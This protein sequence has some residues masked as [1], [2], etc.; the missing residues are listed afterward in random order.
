MHQI[1][2]A[3]EELLDSE[4]NESIGWQTRKFNVHLSPKPMPKRD[5]CGVTGGGPCV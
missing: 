3:A 5:C 2:V 1:P 4:G